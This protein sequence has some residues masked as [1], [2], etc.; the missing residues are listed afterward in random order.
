[1]STENDVARSLRSWLREN[2]YEDADRVLDAVFDQVPATPQRRAGW[3]ARRFP[4]MNS[5]FVR[6]ALVAAV[7]VVAVI[8]GAN[9]LPRPSVGPSPSVT[10]SVAPS[11]PPLLSG[12]PTG[13][14]AAG[15]YRINLTP[16]PVQLTFALPT[17]FNHDQYGIEAI[18]GTSG[19]NRGI[20]FQFA[21]NVYPDP[22]HRAAGAADPAVGPS[23]DDLVTALT[24]MVGFQA[25]PVTDLTI[26]G[27]P[28]KAFDLTNEIDASTCDEQDVRTFVWAGELPPSGSSVGQSE[29]QR[30][31]VV[32]V[33]GTRVMIMSYWFPNGDSA[34]EADAAA[35][36]AAIVDSISRR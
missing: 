33:Q 18:H 25:G 10:P 16:I 32:D 2:R 22:C 28:A 3:L 34:A 6:V 23:V 29:R 15:T 5:N 36:L 1:M 21:S 8:I 12:R 19:P 26:A 11:E 17:G 14:L 35:T 13:D 27:F 7:V 24:S 20:E 4:P 31:Y 9:L 30:I